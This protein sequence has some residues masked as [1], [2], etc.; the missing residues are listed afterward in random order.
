MQSRD[1]K[2]PNM[3]RITH[4]AVPITRKQT[5]VAARSHTIHCSSP[6]PTS[7]KTAWSEAQL[8]STRL[9]RVPL[10]CYFLVWIEVVLLGNARP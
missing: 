3:T 7:E 10:K 8:T 6:S 4:L 9:K 5:P 1:T 2:C